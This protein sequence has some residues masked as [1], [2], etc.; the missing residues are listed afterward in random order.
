[1]SASRRR[2]NQLARSS[3]SVGKG[4]FYHI[5]WQQLDQRLVSAISLEQTRPL[6]SKN[7]SVQEDE[8]NFPLLLIDIMGNQAYTLMATDDFVLIVLSIVFNYSAHMF[9]LMVKDDHQCR[10]FKNQRFL[11][12]ARLA[13]RI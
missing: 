4:S 6:L 7:Q 2:S 13:F 3:S 12:E 10:W 8:T 11:E 5:Q 9:D 1:M